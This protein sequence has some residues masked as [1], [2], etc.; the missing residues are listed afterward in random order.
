MKKLILITIATCWC[1]VMGVLFA[2]VSHEKKQTNRFGKLFEQADS[3]F[4]SQSFKNQSAFDK[5]YTLKIID[6]HEVQCI[7][8]T[9]TVFLYFENANRLSNEWCV[10]IKK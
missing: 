4:Y 7:C 10:Y 3:A 9:D 5:V 1:F 8:K 6:D 2:A